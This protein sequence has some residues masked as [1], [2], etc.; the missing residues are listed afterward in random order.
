MKKYLFLL[1][2]VV[3][4]ATPSYAQRLTPGQKGMEITGSLPVINGERLFRKDHFGVGIS[5]THYPFECRNDTQVFRLFENPL[6][7][8]INL[9]CCSTMRT[10]N[11]LSLMLFIHPC[12]PTFQTSTFSFCRAFDD[13]CK[14]VLKCPIL[15]CLGDGGELTAQ[16]RHL[17]LKFVSRFHVSINYKSNK[18]GW[19]VASTVVLAFFFVGCVIF[20]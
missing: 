7:G 8:S 17:F 3:V 9:Q 4:M 20:R 13:M 1:F 5:F 19:R 12:M 2:C 11:S 10:K 15:L 18:L 16:L 14:A 6:S